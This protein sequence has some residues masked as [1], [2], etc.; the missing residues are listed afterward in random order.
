MN[1]KIL[2]SDLHFGES[3]NSVK[4]N[5]DLLDFFDWVI[6][7]TDSND[8]LVIGGDTFHQRD[9]L[10]VESINY[11][12]SGI[13]KMANYFD[14]VTMIIGNHDMFLKDSRHINSCAVFKHIKNVD[15]IDSYEIDGDLIYVS[16]LCNQEEY[17]ELINISKKNKTKYIIG[18]FEFNSFMVNDRYEM[19]HGHS[20]KELKHIEKV[21]SGH[22]HGRQERDNIIYIGT[23]FP[24]NFNDTNDMDKGFCTFDPTT[25]THAFTNYSKIAVIDLTPEQF[26]ELDLD[27][28]DLNNISVRVVAMDD[29]SLEML[30][31]IKSKFEE[32]NFRTTKLVYKPSSKKDSEDDTIE[33]DHLMSVDQTVLTYIKN[34][35]GSTKIKPEILM[36]LYEESIQN[37]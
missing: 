10:S 24:Y 32:E 2:I 3:G 6:A 33:V 19:E 35:S 8:H 14:K 22:Y 27:E 31:L 12:I 15:I 11:A 13:E 28:L 18:H 21:F 16:W 37:N 25:G 9:K 29:I 36:N 30:D 4:H 26:I 34:M 23:P 17:D 20:H 1:K 5:Q 7:N